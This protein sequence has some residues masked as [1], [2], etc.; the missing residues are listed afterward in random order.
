MPAFVRGETLDTVVPFRAW[1]Y[2]RQAG[3]LSDLVAP[4][5]DVIGSDLQARLHARSPYNVVLVDLGVTHPGDDQNDNKYTRAAGL[6]AR[7]KETGV[8]ERDGRPTVTFVEETFH[9]PDG[10]AGRRHGL[11]AAL[12]LSEFGESIV[13]PHEHTFTGP[14]EDRFRLMTATAMSLSPVFLLYDLPGDEITAAWKRKESVA[15]AENAPPTRTTC[16]CPSAGR[17]R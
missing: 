10:R 12:R 2:S 15:L 16:G 3:E 7:W 14:K 6:L 4:P 8:L 9:G 17:R 5:Y 11:L 13:F 1:R